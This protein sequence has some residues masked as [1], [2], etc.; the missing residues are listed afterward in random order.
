[1]SIIAL[2]A[3]QA[4]ACE[5]HIPLYLLDL[6]VGVTS[7]QIHVVILVQVQLLPWLGLRQLPQLLEPMHSCGD[8]GEQTSRASDSGI[9][10]LNQDQIP[11]SVIIGREPAG[12]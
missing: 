8:K 1:M 9:C 7:R 3:W 4:C 12:F 11:G 6:M 2:R 10:I 5:G